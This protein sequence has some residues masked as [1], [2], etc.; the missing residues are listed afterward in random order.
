MS[1][2]GSQPRRRVLI[3]AYACGP[4][5]GPEAAAGWAFAT[6][7]ATQADVVVITRRRFAD[8]IAAALDADPELAQRITVLHM[9]RHPALV[10]AKRG[11]AGIYWYYVLW[12]RKVRRL[13]AQLHRERR[14]DLVH[15]V[16]FANDWLP[17]GL[18]GATDAPLVW[19]P[20]GG[21]SASPLRLARWLGVRGTLTEV[22]RECATRPLRRLWGDA[23]A[24]TASVVIAQNQDVAHRFRSS[25]HVVVEANASISLD[26]VALPPDGATSVPLGAVTG[27][28]AVYVGRLIPLKG[29]RIAVAA[30]AD[31]ALADWTLDIY[32]DGRERASLERQA[33]RLGLTD[34]VRFLGHRPRAEALAALARADALVFP[35]MH[36]QAGWVAAEASAFG[37]PVVCLPFGGPPSLADV[38]A[39]V[40]PLE[41]D[42]PAAVARTVAGLPLERGVRSRRWDAARLPGFL[43][44]VYA[45]A[46][47]EAPVRA[48]DLSA[49]HGR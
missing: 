45:V 41:K 48:D 37:C 27:R 19:G 1:E 5:D 22:V 14:F 16:T 8:S 38:N 23:A 44:R 3:S 18:V 2:P 12:Q 36:D 31:P 43:D 11:Q 13:A 46:T 42:L 10:A 29:V 24:R 21:A 49:E 9:E 32:G 39:H 35:S 7:A 20:V 30:L 15:H 47:G 40:V 25:R 17:C 33:H 6:A 26:D 34:R 4:G 28:R